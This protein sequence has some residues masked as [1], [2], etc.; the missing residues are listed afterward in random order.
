MAI[1]TSASIS[2]SYLA[3]SQGLR[4]ATRW[5]VIRS[6]F[7]AT[8]RPSSGIRYSGKTVYFYFT[9]SD[10]LG[11]SLGACA[12]FHAGRLRIFRPARSV[13]HQSRYRMAERRALFLA[14]YKG[15]NNGI[16]IVSGHWGFF[17]CKDSGYVGIRGV[18]GALVSETQ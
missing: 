8:D 14:R 2:A 7:L 9:F 5:L 17:I 18:G 1:P 6:P 3:H 15:A 13:H 10:A 4:G 11:A 12:A 16:V